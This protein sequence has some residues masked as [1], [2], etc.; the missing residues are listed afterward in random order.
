MSDFKFNFSELVGNQLNISLLKRSL[1]NG[2]FRQF[3]IFSGI[4]GTGKSTC[5]RIAA[6]SLTCDNPTDGEPCCSC[7]SCRANMSAMSRGLSASNIRTVNAGKLSKRE[8]VDTLIHDIFDMQGSVKNKVFL[9]EEAHALTK[10]SYAETALLSELDNIPSNVYIIFSTTRLF[11]FKDELIS[12]AEK[13]AFVRLS[14][15]ESRQLLFKASEQRARVI[16]E[17]MLNLIIKYGKGIPRNL[18]SALDFL[19]DEDAS[20]EELRAHLQVID[21]TQLVLL[22]ESMQSTE[23]LEYINCLAKIR[24]SVDSQGIYASIKSFL[25]QVAFLLEGKIQGSFTKDEEEILQSIFNKE[26]FY[27]IVRLVSSQQHK[28]S[29]ADLDMMLLQIRMLLQ[30]RTVGDVILDSHKVGAIE[31]DTTEEIRAVESRSVANT[32]SAKKIT[33]DTV[34][35]AQEM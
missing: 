8:D 1:A 31:R 22:F 34:R 4:L 32:T 5:A 16:P 25:V 6:L 13:Y 24:E 10:L 20:V 33:L 15:A 12:R 29:D 19:I 9:I 30:K 28:V 23:I 21:D 7:A 26:S 18:L 35:R 3:T 17:Y 14:D 2:T 11:D 27:K